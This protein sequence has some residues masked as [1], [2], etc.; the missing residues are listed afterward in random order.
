MHQSA[1]CLLATRVRKELQSCMRT[2]NAYSV[3]PEAALVNS[4]LVTDPPPFEFIDR[5][6]IVDLH[7]SIINFKLIILSL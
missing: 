5:K 4:D 1:S 7:A 2:V 3:L 6:Y